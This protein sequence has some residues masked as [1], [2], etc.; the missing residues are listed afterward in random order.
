MSIPLVKGVRRV[1]GGREPFEVVVAAD[2]P[3]TPRKE[4]KP[5]SV[6]T[7]LLLFLLPMANFTLLTLKVFC[8]PCT[9]IDSQTL[10][11]SSLAGYHSSGIL[12]GF[13]VPEELPAECGCP[14]SRCISP[15]HLCLCS[16]SDSRSHNVHNSFRTV[17]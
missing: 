4:G 1:P 5:L 16:R 15:H 2:V 6:L 10:A 8:R 7:C 11:L 14:W 9:S 3:E 13:R 12:R 17:K